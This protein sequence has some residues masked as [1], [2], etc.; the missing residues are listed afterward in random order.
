MHQM[1]TAQTQGV[2][3]ERTRHTDPRQR[4]AALQPTTKGLTSRR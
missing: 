3:T 1:A 2:G 4:D